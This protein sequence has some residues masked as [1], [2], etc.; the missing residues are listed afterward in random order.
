MRI[1]FNLGWILAIAAAIVVAAMGFMSFYYRTGGSLVLPIIVAV[2]LLVLP[3]LV[4]MFLVPA[5]E[6]E[7]PFYFHKEAVKEFSLLAAMVVLF[8]VSL[9]LVNHFF[10]VNSRADEISNAVADQRRQLEEMQESYSKH[11][12]TRADIYRA[13]LNEV[14]ANKDIDQAT[15]DRVFP[16][17]SN[18]IDLM[19]RG[20]KNKIFLE[21]LTDSVTD[22]FKAEKISWWQLPTVMKNVETISTLLDK[23]YDLMVTRDHSVT[24]DEMGQNDYWTFN[25]TKAVDIKSMYTKP[26]GIISS[27]WTVLSVLIAYIL[28]MLPYLS[29]ERDLRSKG[30][31]AELRKSED[32]EDEFTSEN[33]NIGRL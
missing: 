6:C 12:E 19:V 8:V 7:K 2:C 20:F 13:F 1:K 4:N 5:K 30:L 29:A 21:G 23:N 16:N 32:N 27:I 33:E 26:E 9:F 18:D 31:F 10:T 24:D 17:G 28:I 11:V 3:I 15:Y 14:V 22:V 25:Y